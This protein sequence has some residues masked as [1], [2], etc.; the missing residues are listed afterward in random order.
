MG[1]FIRGEPGAAGSRNGS[2]SIFLRNCEN[3]VRED[4]L[5]P[6]R[7]EYGRAIVPIWYVG[8][9]C[10]WPAVSRRLLHEI[11]RRAAPHLACVQH[12]AHATPD[13][14]QRQLRVRLVLRLHYVL[15][16]LQACPCP[17]ARAYRA[18]VVGCGMWA[19]GQHHTVPNHRHYRHTKVQG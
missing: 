18:S 1:D 14:E 2:R 19:T 8:T 12:S 13:P 7:V 16:Q 4:Q 11:V 6:I 17:Q 15:L 9:C 3:T 10:I 5:C